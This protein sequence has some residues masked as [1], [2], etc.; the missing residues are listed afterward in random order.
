MN[1]AATASGMRDNDHID[2]ESND[3]TGQDALE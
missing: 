1:T 3:A 2:H